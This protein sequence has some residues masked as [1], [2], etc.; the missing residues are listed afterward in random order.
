MSVIKIEK[1]YHEGAPPVWT[2]QC[3][4]CEREY[5]ILEHQKFICDCLKNEINMEDYHPIDVTIGDND[6][7][8]NTAQSASAA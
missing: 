2:V 7:N 3:P 4:G 5:R 1:W 8:S 6:G